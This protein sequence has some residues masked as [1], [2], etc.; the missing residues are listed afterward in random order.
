[1]KSNTG[2]SFLLLI[3]LLGTGCTEK[4]QTPLRIGAVLWP[5]YEPLY[6]ASKL[7]YFKDQPV[8]IIDYLSN[9]DAI[10][11]F[12]NNNLNAAA[13]TDRKSVV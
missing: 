1:M 9:T 6:L 4:P 2:F 12:K 3:V 5:G 10:Q 11:A 8:K 13:V 7:G